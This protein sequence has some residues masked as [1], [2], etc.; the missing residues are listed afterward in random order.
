MWVQSGDDY[1]GNICILSLRYNKLTENKQDE[2]IC[3]CPQFPPQIYNKMLCY[4]N[5][6]YQNLKCASEVYGNNMMLLYD[7]AP[8]IYFSLVDKH[9]LKHGIK[10]CCHSSETPM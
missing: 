2:Y 7:R 5:V 10:S 3:K 8:P 9:Q 4:D 1:E 6:L